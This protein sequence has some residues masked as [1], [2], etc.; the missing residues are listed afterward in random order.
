MLQ[1]CVNEVGIEPTNTGDE[2]NGNIMVTFLEFTRDLTATEKTKLDTLMANNPTFPP[3]GGGGYIIK[4]IWENFAQ[5][6]LDAQIPTLQLYYTQ[7]TTG[8]ATDQVY[9]YNPTALTTAQKNRIKTAYTNLVIT[10]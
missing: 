8:G 3:T 6:K 5:F 1:R 9:L 10:V 2:F 7:S 4:D